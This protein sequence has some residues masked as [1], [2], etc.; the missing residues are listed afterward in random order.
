[1]I[2]GYFGFD[3][4]GDEAILM[5]MLQR[6]IPFVSGENIIILSQ[7]P[8]KTIERYKVNA[9]HRLNLFLIL[10]KLNKTGAFISGGG[11]LL[12]DVSGMSLSISY[13]LGLILLAR[14]FKIPC[15]IYAQGIGPVKRKLNKKII[16]LILSKV[17]LIVVRDEPSRLFLEKIGINKELVEVCADPAFLL[18]PEEFSYDTTKNYQLNFI[19]ATENRNTIGIV[20]RNCPEIRKDYQQKILQL[21]KIVDY[22][23]TEHHAKI[24]FIPFQKKN[25]CP[26]Y[27]DIIRQMKCFDFCYFDQEVNASQMLTLFSKLS[28][29]IG[30]RFHAIIFATISNIPFIALDYDPK[31]GNYVNSLGL[32]DLL[33]N[34]DQLTIS[35]I[36]NRLK[37]IRNHKDEIKSVLKTATKYYQNRA[38]VGEKKLEDFLKITLEDRKEN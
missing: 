16:R 27:Q 33:L 11:G 13:Y 24:V 35:E 17:N 26:L 36:E 1:M 21:A 5:S 7:S 38:K 19:S 3:N 12:Q 4:C 15:I 14:L 2:S 10:D 32:S 20:I 18:K 25:D 31:V 37:Y 9:I 34:V 28:L 6:L 30:M 8:H 29:I 23:I 22:L